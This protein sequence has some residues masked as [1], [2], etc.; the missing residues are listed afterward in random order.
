MAPRA[1]ALQN[2]GFVWEVGRDEGRV[3][4]SK[5]EALCEEEKGEDACASR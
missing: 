4:R 3:L 5:K 2:R 1:K